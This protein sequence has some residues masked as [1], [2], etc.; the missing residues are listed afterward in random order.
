MQHIQTVD[1]AYNLR[2]VLW[3]L[4]VASDIFPLSAI[5]VISPIIYVLAFKS[6][7]PSLTPFSQSRYGS[8]NQVTS[9]AISD[10]LAVL[11]SISNRNDVMIVGGAYP[12]TTKGA[13]EGGMGGGTSGMTSGCLF[14]VT[15]RKKRREKSAFQIV[16][17]EE[18][19]V[20][21]SI[22]VLEVALLLFF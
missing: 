16:L 5:A 8:N 6:S 12:V 18:S 17:R 1:G 21:A 15:A 20:F 10:T 14:L 22:E 9:G 13:A 19:I 2:H 3:L 7:L 11:G 4:L